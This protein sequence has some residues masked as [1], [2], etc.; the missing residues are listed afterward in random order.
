MKID[1]NIFNGFLKKVKLE[2]GDQVEEVILDFSEQGLVVKAM[3]PTNTVKVF[4]VLSVDAFIVYEAIGKIGIQDVPTITRLVDKFSEE[5]EIEVNGNI[6]KFKDNNKEMTTELMDIQFIKEVSEMKEFPF[7]DQFTISS[8]IINSMIE[9]A[10]INKDFDIQIE[11][12]EKGAMFYTTGKY[13]FRRNMIAQEAK[14]GVKV[15]FG[16]PFMNSI[17]NLT[18]DV[19]LSL[20]TDFPIKI[21]EKTEH[22]VVT[23]V[24]A[25][26][27][28][29]E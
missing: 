16:T 7:D 13:K 20:K 9:D 23:I 1:K 25:P 6:I 4:G 19:V 22:S 27:K 3:S 12:I 24:T 14:G 18:G 15:A 2:G 10:N 29:S 11:T 17:K 5:I 28:K 8:D 26:L 21:F